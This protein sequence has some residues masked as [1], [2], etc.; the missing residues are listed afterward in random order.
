MWSATTKFTS[1]TSLDASGLEPEN[2][3]FIQVA[4]ADAQGD[5]VSGYAE[6]ARMTTPKA[7]ASTVKNSITVPS[8]KS[9]TIK[10]HGYGHGIGMSQY[11][12]EGGA[13]SG[14]TYGE[15]LTKYYPGTKLADKTGSIRVLISADTTASV[16]IEAAS[17]I[18][19]H[20]GSKTITLPTTV[21]GKKVERWTIDPWSSDKK[22]SVLRYRVA[23]TYYVYD[24]M[25]WTGD[26]QFEAG[27]VR[28]VLPDGKVQAYRTA[29]RSAVPKS[30][31]TDR[32]TV[33][34]L[35]LENYTRGVVAREMPSSWHAEALKAQSVAAR[36]YGAQAMR[37]TGYYDIC[38]TTSCQVYGGVAAEAAS[39][40]QAISATKAKILTYDGSPAL[41]QFSSSS[42]GYTNQGSKPY[43]K[44]VADSW[45]D[46][47]GNANHS[48]SVS[49]KA[50]TIEKKYTA[51]GTLKSMSITQRNGHGDMGGRVTSIKLVGSKASKTISGV[52]ARWAFG[53]KSDWFGF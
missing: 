44:P 11:G 51:I 4:T 31:S 26:A 8:S 2:S 48:W 36:T 30:G 49:V 5:R 21:G 28:L 14:Q 53:L 1:G 34:V 35:S 47:S 27:Q 17:G 39:T 25:T 18:T 33:N 40:D 19:F 46:W 52:D 9:I 16:V 32:D 37:G 23:G 13:R 15:I 22:K 3:Y 6:T 42:G 12:A 43:L 38:D 20:Q 45:D 41:A 10:G 50:S 29:V 24:S 7:S